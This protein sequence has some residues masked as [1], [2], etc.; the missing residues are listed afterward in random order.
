MAGLFAESM[1]ELS[2]VNPDALVADGFEG[3]YV[4]YASQYPSPPLAVYDSDKCISI[5]MERDGMDYAGAVEFFEFNVLG[6]YVGEGTPLFLSP[7][8]AGRDLEGVVHG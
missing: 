1:E 4:G 3:A 8:G 5:L 7:S 2:E 6:A